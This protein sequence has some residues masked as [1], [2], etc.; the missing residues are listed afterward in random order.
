MKILKSVLAVLFVI[1][2]FTTSNAQDQ[3]K[4]L[5][6]E[7]SVKERISGDKWTE[8]SKFQPANITVVLDAKKERVIVYS[9]EVQIYAILKFEEVIDNENDLIYPF[10]CT[11]DDG[12]RFTVSFITRKKQG[13][14]K[15]LYLNQKDFIIVYNL[16]NYPE[17]TVKK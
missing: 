6:T 10:T 11:D 9:Q 8:W 14:R 15:Q 2:G 13:N 16:K 4:F 1:C 12:R 7:F 5:A 3:Y 17:N